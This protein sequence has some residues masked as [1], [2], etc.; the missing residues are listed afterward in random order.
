MRGFLAGALC[1]LFLFSTGLCFGSPGSTTLITASSG[2]MYRVE[3]TSRTR[4]RKGRAITGRLLEPIYAE[5]HLLIPAGATLK[6]D[7][8][9]TRPA[10]RG[11]RLDAKF[12]GDF[13]P[14]S[15][16]VIQWTALTRTD[17]SRYPLQ[18]ES[19][20]NAGSTLYFRAA[21][22]SHP[23][24]FQRAW[25][26]VVGRKNSAVSTVTAPHKWE[27]LQK[28]FWSQMPYH[29]QY[30][31][32][33]T[34]YEMA[35][36]RD[37]RLPVTASVSQINMPKPLEHLVSV[38]SR[39]R[40]DL[41]SASARA[42]DPVEAIVTQPV[43]DDQNRL[44]IPQDSILHGKVLRA[45]RSRRWGRNGTLRFTFEEVTLPSG[46]RQDI[47][48]TPTAIEASPDTKLAIDQ[49]GGVTPQ[50]N[51]SIAAPLVMGLL[52][53]SA[54]GDNDGAFGSPAVASNGFALIG[55]LAAIGIGSRYIGG[56]IGAVATARSIYTRW[57]ATGKNT[58]FAN[59]TE[60]VL[61]MSP[62][63]ATRMKPVQ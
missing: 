11:K 55:R 52:S 41:T 40:S 34:Q 46:F 25:S 29:P 37:L 22:T 8:S 58:H 2:S 63:R 16:P 23:S 21:R 32:E 19:T 18:A 7:I 13:T 50:T 59:N 62:A 44:L 27:R 51:R 36:T 5:N 10:A 9:A 17:G 53:A 31:D 56:S 60:V 33:G 20:G 30:V 15:Q 28:F 42:G 12:H 54:I 43:F 14:L 39:L 3:V 49:E 47:E 57:L 6:G 24:L 61:E 35:L 1:F 4:L 48:A 45:T 38:H 26:T